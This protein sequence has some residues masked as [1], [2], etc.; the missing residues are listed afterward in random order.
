M[1]RRKLISII[2][3]SALTVSI[4]VGCGSEKKV[5]EAS[6]TP[7]QEETTEKEEVVEEAVATG[8]T[9]TKSVSVPADETGKKKDVV[10]A[11]MTFKDGEPTDLKIDTCMASGVYKQDAS[12]A[13]EYVMKEGEEK[14][15][16]EQIDLLIDYL[17]ANN[18]D[19]SKVNLVDDKGNTDAVAGV[20]IKV[21]GYLKAVDT[22]LEEVK[23]GGDSIKEGFSGWLVAETPYDPTGKKADVVVTEMLF[24]DNNPVDVK[25]DTKME[26]GTLKSEASAAGEYV[27]KEGEEKA[28]H[29]QVALLI[30]FLKANDF[31]TSKVTLIDDSEKTDAVAG[32]SIKV[33]AYLEGVNNLLSKVK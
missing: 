15:W 2:L 27:M 19:T 22:L 18:Y 21:P 33:P 25:I 1:N 7:A 17:K 26:D 4:F 29:E 11:E 13:G 8:F 12:R 28:W 20:S 6:G 30:D 23:N 24:E 31:D 32:V 10:I 14:A 16:H 3:V 5:E 9:G